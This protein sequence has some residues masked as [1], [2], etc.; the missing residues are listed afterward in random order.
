M[1]RASAYCPALSR[2]YSL[3]RP[4][5]SALPEVTDKFRPGRCVLYKRALRSPPGGGSIVAAIMLDD[6]PGNSSDVIV[7]AVPDCREN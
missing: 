5:S 3:L 4:R 6:S 2:R 1:D 7:D